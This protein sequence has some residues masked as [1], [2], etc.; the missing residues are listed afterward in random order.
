MTRIVKDVF[1]IKKSNFVKKTNIHH[2]Q[3]VDLKKKKYNTE[4]VPGHTRL[5]TANVIQNL[6]S[7]S[8]P[9]SKLLIK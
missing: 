8:S 3:E 1:I 5:L 6:R 7:K 2:S 9:P 4:N